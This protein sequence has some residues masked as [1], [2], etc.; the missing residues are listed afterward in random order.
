M[1]IKA[2][3]YPDAWE[4][5]EACPSPPANYLSSHDKVSAFLDVFLT[6]EFFGRIVVLKTQGL[7]NMSAYR[8][9]KKGERHIVIESLEEAS[10]P[11]LRLSITSS[12]TGRGHMNIFFVPKDA[13]AFLRNVT[14][15]GH[16]G[17]AEPVTIG[18]EDKWDPLDH[19]RGQDVR[20]LLSDVFRKGERIFSFSH[21]ADYLYE[22]FR[23]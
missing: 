6:S 11:L 18:T 20:F 23:E 12:C 13:E 16:Y 15:V 7:G 10:R 4:F 21:D 5:S 1:T 19:S 2:N 3:Q 9:A 14:E 8:I 17:K 22:I